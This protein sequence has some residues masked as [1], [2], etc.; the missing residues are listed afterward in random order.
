MSDGTYQYSAVYSWIDNKG[1]Q[2]RSAPSVPV[3]VV[4]TAGTTTQQQTIIID[5]LRITEKSNVT[6]ELY[7]TEGTGTVFYQITSPTAPTYNNPSVDSIA[8]IDTLAD[9][10]I[11]S[12]ELLYTTSDELENIAPPAASIIET[13]QNRVFL[14]GLED[15]NKLQYSKIREDGKPVEFNDTLT[16]PVNPLGGPIKALA[17]M[18]D[19]LIIFKNTSIF[20]LSGGGPNNQGEQ[21]T[22][23][24]VELVSSDVGCVDQNSVVL[25][26]SGLMFKS[27]KGI[28]LLDPTL[29]T[30]YIGAPIEDYND[31]NVKAATFIPN[32]NQVMFITSG[33]ALIYNYFSNQW[34]TF[35]NHQ[36][37]SAT[38][39]NND[40]YYIRN[41]N[42]VFKS[43]S[44]FTDNGS[45]IRLRMETS[46]MSFAGVQGYQRVYRALL[47]GKYKSA[48]KLTMEAA[49]N[50]IDAYIESKTVD[51]SD[52]TTDSV[53]G[54]SATY[55]SE[56]PYGGT[57][58]QY[59]FRLDF[60]K[61]KCESIRLR[62][63][64]SQDSDYGEG[65]QMSNILIIVGA[66]AS[67]FKPSQSR[68]YGSI[69]GS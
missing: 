9:L 49:Y 37:I 1:Y 45:F 64:E 15:G 56:S 63:T 58:N 19:K 36:G 24:E 32:K 21:D 26:P 22:F 27:E 44:H 40:L 12:N 51:A 39:L 43:A 28:F 46:W 59:Q 50:F 48:H 13:F 55:G 34:A 35:T 62:I 14:A 42:D 69:K 20:Y 3:T 25:M 33:D 61:Q 29:T 17:S 41:N 10:T 18:A 38:V 8:F 6:I 65:L 52:F 16:L 30:S 66:K 54:E 60:A 23:I 5:T 68:I 57:G 11:L 4:L 47:L 53:Y 67:E 2:H 7:R 31:L